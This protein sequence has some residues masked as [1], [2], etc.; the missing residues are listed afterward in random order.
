MIGLLDTTIPCA[1]PVSINSFLPALP[2]IRTLCCLCVGNIFPQLR[3]AEQASSEYHE[4][5]CRFM[6]WYDKVMEAPD[7]WANDDYETPG[8]DDDYNYPE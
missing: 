3:E 5:T 1:N 4:D 6:E 7:E 2:W 8:W